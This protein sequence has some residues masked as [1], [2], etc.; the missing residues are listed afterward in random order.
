MEEVKG[1]QDGESASAGGEAQHVP[2]LASIA[3]VGSENPQG[4]V[5]YQNR[6]Y[7]EP[8]PAQPGREPVLEPVWDDAWGYPP[9]DH[10]RACGLAELLD[11]ELLGLGDDAVR[12]V[13]EA[14]RAAARA[15]PPETTLEESDVAASGA[16][17]EAASQAVPTVASQAAEVGDDAFIRYL[18]RMVSDNRTVEEAKVQR[19]DA[20]AASGESAGFAPSGAAQAKGGGDRGGGAARAA[21]R[22]VKQKLCADAFVEKCPTWVALEEES[23]AVARLIRTSLH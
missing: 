17:S 9:D 3:E 6:L 5:R 16:A 22:A 21:A 23:G 13:A 12:E 8:E 11:L 2:L 7:H 18:V 14:A 1:G 20:A 10:V 4:P 19:G 15:A